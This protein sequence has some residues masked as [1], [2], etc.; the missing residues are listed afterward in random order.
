MKI[1]LP[2]TLLKLKIF[3]LGLAAYILLTAPP[4]LA[5]ELEVRLPGLP[6]SV[7]DPGEYVRYLF[8][9]GLSLAGF[10]AVGAVAIGGVQY[11]LAG[12]SIGNTQK[13][14][15]LIVGALMGV[16][17]LLGSYLLL[18]TIDPKLTN[19]SFDINQLDA[20]EVPAHEGQLFTDSQITSS[21][22]AKGTYSDIIN[23]MALKYNVPPNLIKAIIMAESGGNPNAVNATSGAQGLMQLMSKYHKISNYADPQQNIEAGTQ[24]LS[25]LLKLHNNDAQK[26]IAS[27]NW[28]QGNLKNKCGNN[29]NCASLPGETKTYLTRVNQYWRNFEKNA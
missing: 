19:L 29:L 23:A 18:Y 2:K 15:E 27:Y 12:A 28:G 25:Q 16:G 3:F 22:I 14:K 9:F 1:N 20:I 10:L 4:A 7:S 6:A 17:L 8:I 13:A 11:M 26:T 21:T 5:Y 24:Y